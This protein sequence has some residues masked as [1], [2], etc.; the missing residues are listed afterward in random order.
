MCFL[1]VLFA[2][3]A[4]IRGEHWEPI[5]PRKEILTRKPVAESIK[6]PPAN[7]PPRPPAEMRRKRV[8]D[9]EDAAYDN[10]ISVTANE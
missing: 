2:F 8:E 3:Q 10:P 6:N 5:L 9:L 1:C 7:P 4:A